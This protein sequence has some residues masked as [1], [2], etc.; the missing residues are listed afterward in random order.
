MKKLISIILCLAM[1]LSFALVASAET[2]TVTAS[3]SVA[4]LITQY[5]WTNTTT[6]QEFMLDDVVTVKIDGGSNTGKAYDGD[7]IRIY[8]TDTPAGTITISVPD[9]CELVSVKISTVTGTY[10]YLCVDGTSTDISNVSTSVSGNS[11]VLNSVK[12][13]DSGKQVR[14][15]AFEVV[16]TTPSSVPEHQHNSDKVCY[17][18]TGHWTVCTCGD[19]S[20]KSAVTPHTLVNYTCECGYSNPPA[21]VLVPSP[22]VGT[23]YK[24]GLVQAK[25][26]GKTLYFAGTMNGYYLATT[27]NSAEATD[28]Y[29]ETVEGGLNLYFMDGETKTYIDVVLRDGETNKVNVVLTTTPTCVWTFDTDLGT[30]TTPVGESTWYLGTYNTF[31]TISASNTSYITGENAANVGVSQ[32]PVSMYVLDVPAVEPETP[33]Q[34]G[35]MVSVIVALMTVAAAGAV[36]ISKKKF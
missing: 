14:V 27:E 35:D 26:D 8:A 20:T 36:V 3:K 16:Y 33:P 29:L 5:G 18:E 25:L 1:V 22:V 19:E 28:V 6:K 17:D 23:A 7:H 11:V 15:T 30:F 9:G 34:T 24:M 32:F 21:T 10:A 31:A 4:D 12:N 2:T 13:G